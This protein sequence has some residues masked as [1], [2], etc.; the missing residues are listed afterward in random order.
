MTQAREV[1]PENPPPRG[2]DSTRRRDRW[3]VA[4]F[5]VAAAL[6]VLLFIAAYP[7]FNNVD[8]QAH[9]DNICRYSHGDIPRALD[10][11][12]D[13]AAT[14]GEPALGALRLTLRR[15]LALRRD[16]ILIDQVL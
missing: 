2:C 15:G 10:H 11:Y 12:G 6:R 9:F 14:T 13:E 3:L 4:V 1:L 7:F 8:E 16:V 5:C